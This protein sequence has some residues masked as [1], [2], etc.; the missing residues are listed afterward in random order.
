M[1]QFESYDYIMH[2]S[3]LTRQLIP[4]VSYSLVPWEHTETCVE[5][6]WSL[7][8]P[9]IKLLGNI[10]L[11]PVGHMNIKARG[12][13]PKSKMGS[14]LSSKVPNSQVIFHELVCEGNANKE[15]TAVSFQSFLGFINRNKAG[16]DHLC[17]LEIRFE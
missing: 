3:A 6:S 13:P 12:L 14:F 8:S 15:Q 5:L 10:T 9:S 4:N 11:P 7:T 16:K 1:F 17:L 2:G